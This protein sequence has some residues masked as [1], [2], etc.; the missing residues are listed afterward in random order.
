MRHL[1]IGWIEN[2]DSPMMPSVRAAALA[3]V[4]AILEEPAML[5]DI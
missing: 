1:G 2:I 4:A 3:D 5:L